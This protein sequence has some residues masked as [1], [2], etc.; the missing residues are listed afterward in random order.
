MHGHGL[1]VVRIN[2][3]NALIRISKSSDT[4][5]LGIFDIGYDLEGQDDDLLQEIINWLAVNCR[6][7]FIV[8]RI[9]GRIVAGGYG[10]NLAASKK[11]LFR[12]NKRARDQD[13]CWVDYK[14]RLTAHDNAMFSLSWLD[15]SP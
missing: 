7:N 13:R 5:D 15:Y 12:I 6:D 1:D 2:R 4:S 14:I 11:G 3:E 10:N 9:E 8:T